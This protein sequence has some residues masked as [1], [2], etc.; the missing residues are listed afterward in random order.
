M[1]LVLLTL[2]AVLAGKTVPAG[3]EELSSKE[4]KDARKLY[5][6]KCAR[7]HKFYDPTD[8]NDQEWDAWLKKMGRKSRLKPPQYDLLSRYLASVRTEAKPSSK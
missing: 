6:A 8:Y 3:G 7:C 5:T 1:R 4:I 2:T